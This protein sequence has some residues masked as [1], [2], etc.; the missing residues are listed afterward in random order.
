[1]S[2]RLTDAEKRGKTEY[3]F[4]VH[5]PVAVMVYA[6]SKAEAR[7]IQKKVMAVQCEEEYARWFDGVAGV[8]RTLL[9]ED[10]VEPYKHGLIEEY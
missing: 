6:K 8:D 1:M 2:S 4:Y 3:L 9:T 5:R 7:A 10:P